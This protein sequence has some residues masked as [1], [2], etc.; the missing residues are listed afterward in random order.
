MTTEP[1][2]NVTDASPNQTE[3]DTESGVEGDEGRPEGREEPKNGAPKSPRWS[4]RQPE[5]APWYVGQPGAAPPQQPVA[6]P[7]P[8][9]GPYGQS[10]Y[11]PHA[12]G[13]PGAPVNGS[14]G[15][16]SQGSATPSDADQAKTPERPPQSP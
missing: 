15:D 5:P 10:P 14:A 13:R 2:E 16:E 3:P 7:T 6:W 8:P 12:P 11:G 4:E 1:E 9:Q